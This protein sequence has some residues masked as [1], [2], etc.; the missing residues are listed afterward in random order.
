MVPLPPSTPGAPPSCRAT[1]MVHSDPHIP[2]VPK[3]LVNFVLNVLAPVVHSQVVALMAK[4]FRREH[5][6]APSVFQRRMAQR[7]ELYTTIR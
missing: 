1:M 3:V 2:R 7:P 6:A 4:V 5:G